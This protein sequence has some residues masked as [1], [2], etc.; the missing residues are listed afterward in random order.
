MSKVECLKGRQFERSRELIIRKLLDTI[1]LHFI[2]KNLREVTAIK[3]PAIKA[4]FFNFW[5]L[6]KF[7]LNPAR[8]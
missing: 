1:F 3:K 4:D 5:F 7:R 8:C 6:P 2:T